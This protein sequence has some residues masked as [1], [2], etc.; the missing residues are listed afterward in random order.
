MVYA[1]C[2]IHEHGTAAWARALV[3]DSIFNQSKF[4]TH[5]IIHIL[6]FA[7]NEFMTCSF[8]PTLQVDIHDHDD[9]GPPVP[10]RAHRRFMLIEDFHIMDNGARS[11]D[12]LSIAM[13][14]GH[15]S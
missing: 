6:V 4:Q 15:K 8:I 2:R 12:C 5:Q 10:S 9:M 13:S 11:K 14:I 3:D 1:E 7:Q